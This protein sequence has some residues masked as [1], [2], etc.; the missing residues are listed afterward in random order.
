MLENQNGIS[1]LFQA[2]TQAKMCSIEFPPCRPDCLLPRRPR[3]RRHHPPFPPRP[4]RQPRQARPQGRRRQQRSRIQVRFPAL[5]IYITDYTYWALQ[6][7]LLK[8]YYTGL[9]R[10]KGLF[11]QAL[12]WRGRLQLAAARQT[13]SLNLAPFLLVNPVVMES[14]QLWK[15]A[16]ERPFLLKLIGPSGFIFLSVHSKFSVCFASQDGLLS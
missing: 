14:R 7:F 15:Q 3:F 5:E 8:P 9:C 13:L 16:L 11:C 4:H 2:K 10:K 12:A 6:F 1:S